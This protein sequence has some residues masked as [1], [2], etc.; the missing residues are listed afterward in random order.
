MF[1]WLSYVKNEEIQQKSFLT[2]HIFGDY[3]TNL[4]CF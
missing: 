3:E 1:T 2:F 4:L